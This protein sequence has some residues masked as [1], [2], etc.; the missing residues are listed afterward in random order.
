MDVQQGAVLR[1]VAIYVHPDYDE[2][3]QTH[4]V[5][6][7]AMSSPQFLNRLDAKMEV[8]GDGK[9]VP[10]TEALGQALDAAIEAAARDRVRAR[11]LEEHDFEGQVQQVIAALAEDSRQSWKAPVEQVAKAIV[12]DHLA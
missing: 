10:P 4:R 2:W 11:L 5:E 3:L 9:L 8:Y 12:D 1:P 7:N 6:L